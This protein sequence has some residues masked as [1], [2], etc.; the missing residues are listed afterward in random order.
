MI[1]DLESKTQTESSE[2]LKIPPLLKKLY[3]FFFPSLPEYIRK[4]L[5]GCET[6]LDLGC[7]SGQ[8]S[9]LLNTSFTYSLG[10]DI[11]RPSLEKCR[12]K[13]IHQEY[14]QADITKLEFNR[15]SFDAVLMLNVLEH[16]SREE[17]HLMIAKC[18]A[19]SRKKVII[20]TPN[21]YLRQD[22]YD[23]NEFMEHK[24]GWSV[25]DMQTLGFSVKGSRGWKRLRGYRAIP[26]YRPVLIWEI[27]SDITQIFTYRYPDAAFGLL[28]VRS[29][30]TR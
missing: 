14:I 7:G 3:R 17:G 8:Y 13:K 4:E 30:D 28:A 6:V 20:S 11:H 27:I 21:G 1:A 25:E 23:N 22:G 18:L 16:L 19:W 2:I 5:A 9:P 26:V 29:P 10:V 24:S 15:H 12:Q